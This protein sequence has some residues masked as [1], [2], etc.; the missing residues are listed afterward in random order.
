M[1]V[2]ERKALAGCV[3]LL[4]VI[5]LMLFVAAGSIRYWQGWLYWST[6]AASVITITLYFLKHDPALVARRSSAGPV[7]EPET[8]QKIIQT[9]ASIL[10]CGE[11]IIP[12]LD[13]RYQWS[14]VPLGLVMA[15]EL[16]VM[17]GFVVVFIVLKENSY[18]SGVIRV[19]A[20][21]PVIS[22]GLYA[23]MR[24][25]MY[26]GGML[27]LIGTPLVLG[28]WWGIAAALALCAVIVV[29]LLDEE[30]RLATELKGYDDYRRKVG[31]RLVPGVW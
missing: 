1:S 27:L 18:A 31:Y 22:T 9:L 13:H 3:F 19:E 20:E 10:F 8:A 12:G 24:H 4:L 23:H 21:Q 6:F 15:G 25:P 29:R 26:A 11:L 5:G 28:S 7:A 16:L 14:S 17:A 2:I 30:G